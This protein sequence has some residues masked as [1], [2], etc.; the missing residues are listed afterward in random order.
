MTAVL[1]ATAWA[2]YFAHQETLEQREIRA[3]Q[4][5]VMA[6]QDIMFAVADSDNYPL[7][8]IGESGDIVIWNPALSELTGIS[9]AQAQMFADVNGPSPVE[10]IICDPVKAM[11][12]RKG[13]AA[14]FK[15]P[16]NHQSLVVVH[17]EIKNRV[18][19]KIPV[20]VSVRL[21]TAGPDKK[22]YALARIDKEENITEVTPPK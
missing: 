3:R 14:A 15:E 5:V 13:F 7:A 18:G 12:H 6:R 16:H 8:V 17:C 2:G 19:V 22:N 21:V 20:R 4:N 1:V 10:S 9:Q 11:R